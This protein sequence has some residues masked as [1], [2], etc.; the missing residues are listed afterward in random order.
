V[1][2]R[3]NLDQ[4]QERYKLVGETFMQGLM[5]GDGLKVGEEERTFLIC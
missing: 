3:K 2:V 5:R 4:E 1:G